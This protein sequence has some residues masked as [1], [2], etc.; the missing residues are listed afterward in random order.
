LKPE[1]RGSR[2]RPSRL[3]ILFLIIV[4]LASALTAVAFFGIGG[5]PSSSTTSA[6]TTQSESSV[7]VF[8][9]VGTTG[10]G[11]HPV[12]L[13]FTSVKTS[14]TYAAQIS[15]GHFYLQL[16][17]QDTYGV[18]VE[19]AG[20]FTWQRGSTT[21]D[22]LTLNMSSGSNLG[23]SYNAVFATPDSTVTVS[24]TVSWQAVAANPVNIRFTAGDGENF[25]TSVN[26]DRS[27][28]LL[29]PNLMNYQVNVQ[30]Q[31]SSGYREWYYAHTLQVQAGTDVVGLI[32]KVAY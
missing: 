24:G 12:S 11:T 8:G 26:P 14:T 2:S 16:P 17:N 20:N 10:S 28:S 31:N 27:F 32:V 5:E 4:V 7:S 1:E 22:A 29:L 13:N 18:V 15:G 23:W 6:S 19:W 25:T 9:L 21:G 3:F 30:S